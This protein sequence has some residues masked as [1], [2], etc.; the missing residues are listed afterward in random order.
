[1]NHGP[2]VDMTA[3][4]SP[5][6]IPA[7]FSSPPDNGRTRRPDQPRRHHSNGGNR[8][9]PQRTT[10]KTLNPDTMQD[11]DIV[12]TV[13]CGGTCPYFPGVAYRDWKLDDPA[14]QPLDTIRA[15]RD[16]IAAHFHALIAEVL[17]MTNTP[18]TPRELARPQWWLSTR[19]S[20]HWPRW[21]RCRFRS[22]TG[23]SRRL[24]GDDAE[25]APRCVVRGVARH[26]MIPASPGSPGSV[27][28]LPAATAS[29]DRISCRTI[30]HNQGSLTALAPQ[31][32]SR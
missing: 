22:S 11:S 19:Y 14:G 29:V 28:G 2:I 16:D 9:R 25:S 5:Q 10:P 18:W 27:T 31:P 8:H 4:T 32:F 13:G 3:A 17:P 23:S 26:G 15:I 6:I 24:A 30:D 1:M 21:T 20:P 7:F 12:I